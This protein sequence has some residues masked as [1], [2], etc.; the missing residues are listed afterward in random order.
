MKYAQY[1]EANV[2]IC[3]ER[4]GLFEEAQ[5]AYDL[6]MSKF[7]DDLSSGPCNT[8]MNSEVML[9]EQQWIRC[10]KELN[11][12]DIQLDYA[13]ANREQNEI[14]IM[15]SAWRV[16]NWNLMKKALLKIEQAYSKLY[17]F[18][19]NLYRG[20][21]AILHPE[22]RQLCNVDKYVE[23]A[24][25]LCIREWHRLPH[26]LSHIHLQAAQQ[27]I[28][29]HEAKQLIFSPLAS[30]KLVLSPQYIDDREDSPQ[31]MVDTK[32]VEMDVV[33]S[34]SEQ[35]E[36]FNEFRPVV[37]Q[38]QQQPNNFEEVHLLLEHSKK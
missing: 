18:K 35:V 1:P 25:G 38:Q 9:W 12:W 22:E 2:A 20:F 3:Y 31:Q 14:L 11:Q 33:S 34:D 36:V 5:G 37:Q 6:A 17:D 23:I 28:E 29:I 7:E 16:P 27:I 24:S 19:V 8:N 26:I 15:Q 10:A 21:L 32:P 4:M 13:Q 30:P